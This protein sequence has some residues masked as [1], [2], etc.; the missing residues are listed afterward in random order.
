LHDVYGDGECSEEIHGSAT[1][2]S[3]LCGSLYHGI[4]KFPSER[5]QK[6]EEAKYT[7]SH[8]GKSGVS[9][10]SKRKE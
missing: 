8:A 9:P 3:Y 10:Y 6:S 4:K 1:L 2:F 7:E 5:Y